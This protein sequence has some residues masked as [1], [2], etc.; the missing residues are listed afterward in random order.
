MV[1]CRDRDWV[2]LPS[3]RPEICLL[4]PLV[5]AS[6]EA[7]AVHKWLGNLIG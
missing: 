2:L 7:V 4:R 3:N 1:H 6:D 5:G